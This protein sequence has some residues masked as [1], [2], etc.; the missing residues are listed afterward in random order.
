[1]SYQYPDVKV[2]EVIKSASQTLTEPDLKPCPVGALYQVVRKKAIVLPLKVTN[3]TISYPV[4]KVGSTV[5][6]DSVSIYVE[7][8]E[9]EIKSSTTIANGVLEAG[10]NTATLTDG[11][12]NASPGDILVHSLASGVIAGVYTIKS[13]TDASNVILNE[14]IDYS[15]DATDKLL[16]KRSVGN[17]TAVMG[18]PTFDNTSVTISSLTYNS[19]PIIAGTPYISYRALRKDLL[20]FYNV[21][22]L[23]QLKVDMDVDPWNPL[24]LYLGSI[25]PSA[26]G[27]KSCIAYILP[28]ELD[29]SFIT[30]TEDLSVNSDVYYLVPISSSSVVMNTMNSHV[31]DMSTDEN[32]MFRTTII[33]TPLVTEKVIASGT[34]TK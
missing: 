13:K 32:S 30:A 15:N 29:S 12:T 25:M 34:F 33:N 9:I 17:V 28:D 4:I 6:K 22:S 24:G 8:A 31:T 27:G 14:S 2:N 3:A 19:L 7:S 21:D 10:K 20:G 16:I 1:M 11:F 18:T 26:S 5:D 23:E